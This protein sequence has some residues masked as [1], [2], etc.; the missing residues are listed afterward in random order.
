MISYHLAQSSKLIYY[1][2]LY[3]TDPRVLFRGVATTTATA[4]TTTTTRSRA[5]NCPCVL[6]PTLYE[7]LCFTRFLRAERVEALQFER[8]LRVE[9]VEAR[10]KDDIRALMLVKTWAHVYRCS[11]LSMHVCSP[12][13]QQTPTRVKTCAHV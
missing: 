4:T 2:L 1:Y 12:H 7:A 11:P 5:R 13:A 8:C 6:L 3:V 10:W 9:R